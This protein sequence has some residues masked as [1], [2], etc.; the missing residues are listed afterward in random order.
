MT[1]QFHTYRITDAA[2]VGA[3]LAVVQDTAA[4][5]VKKPAAA[6]AVG[7]VGVTQYAQA[8]QNKS[9]SVKEYG[10]TFGVAAGAIAVGDWVYIA[11]NTGKFAS[12][13][14]S[15]NL[16]P[17]TALQINICGKART[18]AAVSGDLFEFDIQPFVVKTAA[19]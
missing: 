1:G 5:D 10:R 14:A 4:G 17:G 7:F 2:G 13:E 9:V 12:C 18:A 3:G 19:S 15:V 11:D 8:T 16:A 6:N